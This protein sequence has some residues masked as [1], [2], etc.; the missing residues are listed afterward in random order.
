MS[1]R[2]SSPRI[3]PSRT[4]SKLSS[5]FTQRKL[6][7]FRKSGKKAE[8]DAKAVL[9][10]VRNEEAEEVD[11][12]ASVQSEPKVARLDRELVILEKPDS[13]ERL[14]DDEEPLAAGDNEGKPFML[15][16]AVSL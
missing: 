3:R 6:T 7:D 14:L 11:L 10:R 13:P 5:A 16:V 12:L 15:G 8:S 4:N 9:K 2:D 1:S